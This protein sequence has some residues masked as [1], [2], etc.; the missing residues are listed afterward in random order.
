M[1]ARRYPNRRPSDFVDG[2]DSHQAFELDLA[3]AV[4]YQ[5]LENEREVHFLDA[6][7]AGVDNLLRAQGQKVKKRKPRKS[8]IK[9]YDDGVRK[10]VDDLPLVDDVI[11]Q[12]TSGKT[13][14]QFHN[15]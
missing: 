4:K 13:V 15:M 14:V 5:T 7:L 9:P 3:L 11:Q 1:L 2:L 10:E 6:I 12:L 8:S